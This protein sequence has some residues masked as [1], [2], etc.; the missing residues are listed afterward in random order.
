MRAR[1]AAIGVTPEAAAVGAGK[2]LATALR[3][4]HA[5]R[6]V[7]DRLHLRAAA[8]QRVLVQQ[9]LG[10]PLDLRSSGLPFKRMRISMPWGQAWVC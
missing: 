9:R 5:L 4:A 6:G 8:R 3:S 7:R 2:A 1:G 10:P